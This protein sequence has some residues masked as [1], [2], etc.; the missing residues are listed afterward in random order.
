MMREICW[1]VRVDTE[2]GASS[3][4]SSRRDTVTT[5]WLS[6]SARE[7]SWMATDAV[8]PAS[9][10]T[11]SVREDSWPISVTRR[12]WVPAGTGTRNSPAASVTEEVAV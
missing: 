11:P 1:L 2:A 5:S 10:V 9:T 3:S 12:E 8:S 7:R 4:F 6:T